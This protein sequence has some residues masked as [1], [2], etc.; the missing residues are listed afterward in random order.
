[1]ATFYSPNTVTSGLV[2]HLDAANIRSYPGTGNSWFDLSGNGNT[3]TKNGNAANPVWNS[4][5][6]FTFS[7]TSLGTNNAFTVADSATM[8]DI[9]NM[10]VELWFT[11]ETK[12]LISGDSDWMAI[13]SKDNGTRGDQRPAISIN[14]GASGNRYLHIE[15]PSAFNSSTDLFTNYTGTQWYCVTATISTTN[16]VSR[17]YLNGV[18]VSSTSGGMTGNSNIFYIGTDSQSE[19]FKGRLAIVKVYNREL[20]VGEITQNFNVLRNR[21][22]I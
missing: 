18:Q 16:N 17:G 4:V 10:T 21:F 7:A 1:M 5:G 3:A 22:G 8:R 13:V 9:N 11:L 2:L 20:S 15:R 6:Y 19:L 14:Q 12:T